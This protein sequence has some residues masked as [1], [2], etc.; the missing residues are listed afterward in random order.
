MPDA[1]GYA[2][3]L[4]QMPGGTAFRTFVCV[5]LRCVL[6]VQ[7]Q[8]GARQGKAR[9]WPMCGLFPGCPRR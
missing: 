5:V 2:M 4:D 3:W 6:S 1:K 7:G 9:Q 8:G